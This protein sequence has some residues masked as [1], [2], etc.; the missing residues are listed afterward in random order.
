MNK[1]S[2]TEQ[3][4][5]SH[6]R[7]PVA[8]GLSELG[9]A[10]GF[11]RVRSKAAMD[12]PSA[13]RPG[14]ESPSA[15]EPAPKRPFSS[16]RARS[17]VDNLLRSAQQH[18]VQLSVMA[19]AKAGM[20][21]TLSSIVVTVALSQSAVGKFRPA[22][23]TLA[24]ACL[25]ALL[26]AVIA[27]LPTFHSR[28]GGARPA[29]FNLLFFGHFATMS[30]QEYMA[31]LE[32]ALVDDAMVYQVAAR[33]IHS[34][35]VYLFRKKYRFLRYAYVALIGGFVLAAMVEVVVLWGG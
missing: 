13:D 31:E 28:S 25:V 5:S 1:F 21:I 3:M 14:I 20:L 6:L 10:G 15:A 19:D 12:E 30:E 33:D 11:P 23:F 18:H 9:H 16:I 32:A 7:P 4:S 26:F 29:A 27:I 2:T 17:S 24:G 35:G 34:L 8:R 22:L